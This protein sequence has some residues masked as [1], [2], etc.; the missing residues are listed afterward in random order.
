MSAGSDQNVLKPFIL[1]ERLTKVLIGLTTEEA[2]KFLWGKRQKEGYFN[3]GQVTKVCIHPPPLELIIFWLH[4]IVSLIIN[5]ILYIQGNSRKGFRWYWICCFLDSWFYS[6][7]DIIRTL[8]ENFPVY[9]PP[10][11]YV[12]IEF[13][14]WTIRSIK[15]KFSSIKMYFNDFS[16]MFE[17]LEIASDDAEQEN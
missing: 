12:R 10:S 17:R 15:K 13:N 6:W 11:K 8:V 9:K 5:I 4:Y 3:N 7:S 16:I 2:C 14:S 1:Q